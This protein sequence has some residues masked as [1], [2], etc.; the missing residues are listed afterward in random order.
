MHIAFATSRGQGN[1]TD[2]SY[3]L[4]PR[5]IRVAHDPE[6][7]LADTTTLL[8]GALVDGGAVAS[9]RHSVEAGL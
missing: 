4:V 9:E 5:H 1:P 8:D 6:V 2:P 7:P 3:P